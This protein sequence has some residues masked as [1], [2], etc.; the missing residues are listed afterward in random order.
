MYFQN[1]SKGQIRQLNENAHF[2][3]CNVSINQEASL[4][5][6][7]TNGTKYCTLVLSVY[8]KNFIPLEAAH[9]K[10]LP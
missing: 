7:T 4:N 8:S 2:I 3:F 6:Q 1:A 9:Y 10:S 5:C